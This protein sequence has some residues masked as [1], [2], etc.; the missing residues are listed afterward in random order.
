L[1]RCKFWKAD[2]A[3]F[4]S[5]DVKLFCRFCRVSCN[6]L[7]LLDESTNCAR[8]AAET[9]LIDIGFIPPKADRLPLV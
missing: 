3:P 2:W 5:P 6:L 9:G 4:R 8:L 7:E 1:I